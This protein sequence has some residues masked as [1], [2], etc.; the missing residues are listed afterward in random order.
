MTTKVPHVRGPAGRDGGRRR[1]QIEDEERAHRLLPQPGARALAPVPAPA[2]D[3]D[4]VAP[5]HLALPRGLGPGAVEDDPRAHADRSQSERA[6]PQRKHMLSSAD[7]V[8][9]DVDMSSDDGPT[10][11]VPVDLVDTTVLR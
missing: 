8:R 1:Q 3:R 2:G 6:W 9:D 4:V 10:T 11:D 7:P 5:D